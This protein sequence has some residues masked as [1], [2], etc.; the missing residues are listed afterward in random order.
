[1]KWL[2]YAALAVVA[3]VMLGK[4]LPTPAW[5]TGLTYPAKETVKNRLRDPESA[6][7]RNLTTIST[8]QTERVVC[9]EVNA[10]N[11]FGGFVGFTK[12]VVIFTQSGDSA[13]RSPALLASDRIAP[14]AT[15]GASADAIELACSG[16]YSQESV[17]SKVDAPD[18]HAPRSAG[19]IQDLQWKRQGAD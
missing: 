11:G 2:G 1:M 13:R 15:S 6:E 10:R 5:D 4:M 17:P 3:F 18:S 14:G 19:S 16:R 9:G 7:F 8:G 12:F